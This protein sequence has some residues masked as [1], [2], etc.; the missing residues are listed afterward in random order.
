MVAAWM[1]TL[2]WRRPDADVTSL[3][4]GD[5]QKSAH[6]VTVR[7]SFLNVAEPSGPKLGSSSVLRLHSASRLR[8]TPG[9]MVR[10][11]RWP[12]SRGCFSKPQQRSS[13]QNKSTPVSLTYW[14]QFI[15]DLRDDLRQNVDVS[16]ARVRGRDDTRSSRTFLWLMWR[17][18]GWISMN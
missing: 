14:S 9:Q 2:S 5:Q 18:K 15:E 17:T 8:L 7:T 13:F 12:Q 16:G 6:Q 11:P 1:T 3:K 4:S 10:W